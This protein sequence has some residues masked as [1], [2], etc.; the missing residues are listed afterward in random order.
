MDDTTEHEIAEQP[1]GPVLMSEW[2]RVLSSVTGAPINTG[3]G[4][5][6]RVSTAELLALLGAE[7]TQETWLR[8]GAVMRSLDPPWDGPHPFRMGGSDRTTKKGYSRPAPREVD[9]EFTE[10]CSTPAAVPGKRGKDYVRAGSPEEL[11]KRLEAVCKLSLSKIEEILSLPVDPDNGNTLRALTACASAALQAQL[12]ADE[13]RLKVRSNNDALARLLKIIG[14]ERKAAKTVTKPA[15]AL[16]L[17]DVSVGTID[18]EL[19]VDP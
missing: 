16:A 7:R 5:E 14:Q 17:P 4:V 13:S 1:A 10:Q 2:R 18:G 3:T 19:G 6:M 11:A 8:L 15:P 12:R 9:I